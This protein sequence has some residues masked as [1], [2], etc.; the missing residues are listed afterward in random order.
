VWEVLFFLYFT[1]EDY[2]CRHID[3]EKQWKVQQHWRQK[4]KKPCVRIKRA[5]SDDYLTYGQTCKTW[6]HTYITPPRPHINKLTCFWKC[7]MGILRKNLGRYTNCK[8][9]IAV[10]LILK[11]PKGPVLGRV[12]YIIYSINMIRHCDVTWRGVMAAY[13]TTGNSNYSYF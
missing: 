10:D 7:Y 9:C 2:P 8:H 5:T 6:T 4:R 3:H 13:T 12:R 11:Q 1:D